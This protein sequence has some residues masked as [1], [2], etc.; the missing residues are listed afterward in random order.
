MRGTLLILVMLAIFVPLSVKA[1]RRDG[2]STA[3]YLIAFTSI[4]NPE[5]VSQV[6][7]IR[8]DGSGLSRL[9]NTT[10]PASEMYPQISPDGTRVTFS[11]N[12]P[13]FVT[14]DGRIRPEQEH[15]LWVVN[16]VVSLDEHVPIRLTVDRTDTG[17]A[18]VWITNDKVAWNHGALWVLHTLDLTS[19]FIEPELFRAEGIETTEYGPNGDVTAIRGITE[20]A[21]S[22]D[23]NLVA[24]ALASDEVLYLA[25]AD[26][27]GVIA[28]LDTT[29]LEPPPQQDETAI[30]AI[31]WSRTGDELLFTVG[32]TNESLRSYRIG[33]DGSDLT[34]VVRY[35]GLTPYWSPDGQWFGSYVSHENGRQSIFLQHRDSEE[36]VSFEVSSGV[37]LRG[38]LPDLSVLL[39]TMSDEDAAE[40]CSPFGA[41]RLYMLDLVCLKTSDGCDLDDA[42]VV[43]NAV[44]DDSSTFDIVRIAS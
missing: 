43:P 1:E 14:V 25:N 6:Y 40:R 35:G 42:I 39:L 11:S 37:Y 9:T 29:T 24:F 2:F 27:T 33:S 8:L 31:R 4:C 7:T 36:P 34:P 5:R 26:G 38:W 28:L 18:M 21:W 41:S 44:L 17:S 23:G 15:L 22:P 10:V 12:L 16:Y 32:Y 30:D 13:E 19:M 20:W 3:E